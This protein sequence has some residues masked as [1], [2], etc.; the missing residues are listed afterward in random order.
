MY[1]NPSPTIDAIRDEASKR[2]YRPVNEGYE[3]PLQGF[4]IKESGNSCLCSY[5]Y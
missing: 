4:S 5:A 1:N 2:E 3:G